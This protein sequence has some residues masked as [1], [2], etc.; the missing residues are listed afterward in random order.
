VCFDVSH[1]LLLTA[2][3]VMDVLTLSHLLLVAATAA[4]GQSLQLLLCDQSSDEIVV[5]DR[6]SIAAVG[7]SYSNLS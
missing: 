4:R 7:Y 3:V 1:L 2:I 5:V 6:L